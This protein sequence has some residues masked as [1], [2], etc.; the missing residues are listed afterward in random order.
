MNAVALKAAAVGFALLATLGIGAL[1]QLPYDAEAGDHAV[2]RLAWRVRGIRVED[3]RALSPEQIERLPSHMRI[4]ETCEGR[5]LPYRLRLLLDE[6]P[7]VDQL[8]HAS[9]ARGDRPLYVYHEEQV[10]PGLRSIRVGFQLQSDAGDADNAALDSIAREHGT[11]KVLE[12]AA[13][14]SLEAGEVA[15]VTYD[16]EVR[17]LVLRG[18][19]LQ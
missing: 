8:I 10:S 4:T 6:R 1:S 9:G 13:E 5:T 12:L 7:V 17:R 16:A 11:P 14:V 2:V 19:G 15:L 18:Y 3:C